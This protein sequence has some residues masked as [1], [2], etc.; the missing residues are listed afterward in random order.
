MLRN[1]QYERF[2][3]LNWIIGDFLS[4]QTADIEFGDRRRQALAGGGHDLFRERR[5]SVFDCAR[6]HVICQAANRR[7]QELF[8]LGAE[9]SVDC[10]RGIVAGAAANA[11]GHR[12][13]KH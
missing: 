1:R 12:R 4:H 7:D 10:F 9:N 3:S 6:R 11:Q 2:Q 5:G 8:N 13:D